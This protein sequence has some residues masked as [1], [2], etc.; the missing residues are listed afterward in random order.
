LKLPKKLFLKIKLLWTLFI[1]F[2]CASGL[3]ILTVGK[4]G[5]GFFHQN[6]AAPASKHYYG[7]LEHFSF[8][9][10][11]HNSQPVLHFKVRGID[12][13]ISIVGIH[14]CFREPL[15]KI[16]FQVL[17]HH[18]LSSA[19]ET[20]HLWLYYIYMTVFIINAANLAHILL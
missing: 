11:A 1:E 8:Q 9:N 15:N 2:T 6:D 13:M 4:A 17:S 12:F 7:V 3:S 5:K 16:T 10:F 18:V 14:I 20:G 19:K